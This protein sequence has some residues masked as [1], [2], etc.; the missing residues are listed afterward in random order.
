VLEEGDMVHFAIFF[1]PVPL[2]RSPTFPHHSKFLMKKWHSES[3]KRMWGDYTTN[4]Y[5]S[6]KGGEKEF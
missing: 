6:R 5:I 3:K 2:R 4:T 1:L